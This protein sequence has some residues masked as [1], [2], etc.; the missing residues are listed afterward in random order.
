MR[1]GGSSAPDAQRHEH[2]QRIY[3]V[4]NAIPRGRV[5]SYGQVA[6]I[7]GLPGRARQVGYALHATPDDLDLPW[8]RVVNAKGEISRRA[9]PL[10]E[11]LQRSLLEAEGVEFDRHGRIDLDRFRWNPGLSSRRPKQSAKTSAKKGSSRN[12]PDS[13]SRRGAP[14]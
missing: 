12:T 7:A 4:V 13:A 2:R 1:A 11:R 10:G 9:E 8:Q 5:A 6:D 3:A 14:R